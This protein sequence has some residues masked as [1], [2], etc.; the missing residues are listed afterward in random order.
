VRPVASRLWDRTAEHRRESAPPYVPVAEEALAWVIIAAVIYL[1]ALGPCLA[2]ASLPTVT[3]W[4]KY[5]GSRRGLFGV[6]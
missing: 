2:A 5:L 6:P 4:G 3:C 1:G